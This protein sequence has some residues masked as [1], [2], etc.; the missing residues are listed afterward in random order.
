M[1]IY[2]ISG[3][4]RA[5]SVH[6]A[7]LRAMQEQAPSDVEFRVC[8]LVESLPI[9]NPDREGD[10]APPPVREFARAV[11]EADLLIIASPEYAHGIP[12]GLKNAFDWLVSGPE[13]VGK[14]A[15]LVHGYS[16]G[17]GQYGLDALREVLRTASLDLMPGEAFAVP[18]VGL[19]VSEAE[20]LLKT[21][22]VVSAIRAAFKRMQDWFGTISRDPL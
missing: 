8:E 9:F 12:G 20:E 1:R 18:L 7:L 3:S 14:P 19:Q 5:A 4:V 10:A 17:R 13:L 2:A 6:S 21:S 15:V 16:H 11:D 22:E